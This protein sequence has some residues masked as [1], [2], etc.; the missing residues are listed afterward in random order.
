MS[1]ILNIWMPEQ[2]NE[3]ERMNCILSIWMSEQPAEDERM[4]R[5]L[6][7]VDVRTYRGS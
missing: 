3:G 5:I 7:I 2:T 4:N 6:S 1:C